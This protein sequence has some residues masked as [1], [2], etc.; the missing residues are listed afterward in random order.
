MANLQNK[1]AS[2]RS[3]DDARVEYEYQARK[4][5]YE[6][7]EPLRFQ[8]LEAVETAKCQ[9]LTMSEQSLVKDVERLGSTP[10]GKYWI[11][12]A[13]YHL[14]HPAALFCI[15]QRRLTLIDLRM[16][17]R[18]HIE[19]T[20]AKCAYLALSHDAR[21]A[22]VAALPYT[23]YVDGWK[24]KREV[25]PATFRRQGLPLGRLDNAISML[26]VNNDVQRIATFGEFEARAGSVAQDDVSGAV[27]AARDLFAGFSPAI[28][29]VLWRLLLAQFA[30]YKALLASIQR[31]TSTMELLLAPWQHLTGEERAA[32]GLPSAVHGALPTE[33]ADATAYIQAYVV[34]DVRTIQDG[35]TPS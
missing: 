5:L 30:V 24:D 26:I 29:P 7:V 14:L 23:P 33:F 27:G 11:L 16:D 19:Y 32:F 21:M 17:R 22:E 6:Q 34:P 1:L 25:N 10:T 28:R 31:N 18:I 35:L 12:G 9:I 4:R 20:L 8:L 2:E 13:I 15:A 3:R